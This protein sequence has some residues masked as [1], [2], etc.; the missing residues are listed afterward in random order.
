MRIEDLRLVIQVP[1]HIALPADGCVVVQQLHSVTHSKISEQDISR[2]ANLHWVILACRI[3]SFNSAHLFCSIDLL[4][5]VTG[6][7]LP[8][9][10]LCHNILMLLVDRKLGV[11]CQHCRSFPMQAKILRTPKEAFN[12]KC[13]VNSLHDWNWYIQ[14]QALWKATWHGCCWQKCM[15]NSCRYGVAYWHKKFPHWPIKIRKCKWTSMCIAELYCCCILL[16][17]NLA[18]N[19]ECF[20][21]LAMWAWCRLIPLPTSH[22]SHWEQRGAP[23]ASFLPQHLLAICQPSS[24]SASHKPRLQGIC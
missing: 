18:T 19:A 15:P 6:S 9:S 4:V 2:Y 7:V 10:L 11:W 3:S 16:C 1:H 13:S 20:C 8:G 22:R 17:Q 21:N 12:S 23:Y 24:W 5:T 14:L